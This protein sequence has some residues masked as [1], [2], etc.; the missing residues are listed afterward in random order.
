M[1]LRA[2]SLAIIG[3]VSM[4]AVALAV[5]GPAAFERVLPQSAIAFLEDMG[6]TGGALAIGGGTDA[7]PNGT[8]EFPSDY[9]SD[10]A[11]G[12]SARGPIAAMPG[13]RA[14]FIEDV[15]VG[16]S[17]R[18]SRDTPAEITTIRPVLG[19]TFTPPEKGAVVGHAVA[20]LSGVDLSMI[21]Y[22]DE[23][24]ANAVQLFVDLYRDGGQQEA[25]STAAF[26]YQAYDIAVTDTRT[27]IY[28]VLESDERHRI[29]N[30]HVAPGARIER[31]ILLGGSQAGVVN[32]DPVVPVEVML[33][34]GLRECGIAPAY[35]LNDGNLL[36]Q[37]LANRTMTQEEGTAK[38]AEIQLAV[39]QYNQWFMGQFGLDAVKSSAGWNGG[40]I[41]VIGPLPDETNP[42][43]IWAGID[44]AKIRTT[45]NTFFEIEGQV[46][47]GA[48]FASRV[49]AIATSFAWGDLAKLRQGVEVLQ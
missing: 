49:T 27:P 28:L 47:E 8:G 31:V 29:W 14:A 20:R 26:R 40:T 10:G 11:E 30:I 3:I 21:T 34:D 42:K 35:P 38:L 7:A 12:I 4:I 2:A 39:D 43:A 9:L 17:T 36:F 6:V 32:L 22:G 33:A 44:A 48:D 45:Q 5:V 23:D 19:C 16:Y 37:S 24:L 1:V 25:I 15:I 46:A 41:S 13:G 18:V